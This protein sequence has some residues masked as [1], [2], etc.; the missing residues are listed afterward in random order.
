ME[1][2]ESEQHRNAGER[3]TVA[4]IMRPAVTTVETDGHLAAAAYLMNHAQQ[5][6]LVVVDTAD[7]PV[8][9]I[10]EA[11]LLRATA[12]GA[13]TGQARIEDWMNRDPQTIGPDVTASKAARI[14]LDTAS[15]H[16]PVVSDSRLLGIVAV[17]DI[18]DVLVRS[19]RPGSVVVFVSDLTRSLAFYQPLLGYTL[20]ASDVA[21]ALLTGPDGSQLYLR[22]VI[23]NGSTER[24]ESG[25]GLQYVAWTSDGPR[26]LDRCSQAL[27]EHGAYIR[28]DTSDGVDVLEGRDPDGLPVLITYPGPDQTQPDLISSHITPP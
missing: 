8:A 17:T 4:D 19:I 6:A 25:I 3:Y 21:T 18:V 2:Q 16:L 13:E 11:D 5:S 7:R 24:H 14:M 12:Q 15:R 22:Q 28:R 1:P 23:D 10:T 27:T 26:D 9:L 20:T